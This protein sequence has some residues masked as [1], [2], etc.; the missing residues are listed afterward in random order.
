MIIG[1]ILFIQQC[2]EVSSGYQCWWAWWIG[3]IGRWYCSTNYSMARVQ[4]II[5]TTI[6]YPNY[7]HYTPSTANETVFYNIS[8]SFLFWHFLIISSL[9]AVR[10]VDMGWWGVHKGACGISK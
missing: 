6:L 2:L 3:M 4:P 1:N 7:P 10:P 8:R 9:G 5:T